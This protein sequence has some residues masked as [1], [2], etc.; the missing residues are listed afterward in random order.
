[1]IPSGDGKS[2]GS[3]ARLS[4]VGGAAL[5]GSSAVAPRS[6]SGGSGAAG[7]RASAIGESLGR[8]TEAGRATGFEEGWA[9][10][11]PRPLAPRRSA[12]HRA[13]VETRAPGAGL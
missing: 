3:T 2:G 6:A 11:T 7:R 1:M 13:W 10:R 9:R 4:E 5:V 8:A 12:A